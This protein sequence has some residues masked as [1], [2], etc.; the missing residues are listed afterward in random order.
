MTAD[1]A[2]GNSSDVTK[3]GVT[4]P[5][6]AKQQTV[7]DSK[8]DVSPAKSAAGTPDQSATGVPGRPAPFATASAQAANT[9]QPKIGDESAKHYG[10][11]GPGVEEVGTDTILKPGKAHGAQLEPAIMTASGSL[12]H[13]QVPTPAGSVPASLI[14]DDEQRKAAVEARK[15]SALAGPR[16]HKNG[17][18]RLSDKMIDNMNPAEL[19]AVAA[20]RG[21]DGVEGG[22]VAIR[23]AF[24]KAQADDDTLEGDLRH[25]TEEQ[26]T[27]S[28]P[29][30]KD[31]EE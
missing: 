6:I 9:E 23:A 11:A 3:P 29:T 31:S 21:Y 20:D 15:Q 12:P 18:N 1:S 19:R 2:G 27:T 17:R 5:S 7:P 28:S 8:K 24:R 22:K 14:E 13:D 4:P 25:P 16:A 10:E 26:D 30:S